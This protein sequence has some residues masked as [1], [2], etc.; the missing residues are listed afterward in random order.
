M[1]AP[2]ESDSVRLAELVATLSYAADLGLSQ[3]MEHCMRQTVIAL[4][5]A[6]L[7]GVSDSDREATFYLGLLM[8][9]YCHVDA[10]EQPAR[11]A[12]PD[13]RMGRPAR[14]DG[15]PLRPGPRRGVP[16]RGRAEAMS[17]DVRES[18]PADAAHTAR[19]LVADLVI[20]ALARAAP[21]R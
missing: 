9:A 17:W 14:Q 5:L 15:S 10:A 21:R 11:Q 20:D 7:V 1:A 2:A 8:N 19:L 16:R 12:R 6:D 13:R 18:G 3:P 4:R